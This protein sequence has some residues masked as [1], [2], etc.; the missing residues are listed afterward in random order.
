MLVLCNSL[1]F[2]LKRKKNNVKEGTDRARGLRLRA[3]ALR[4]Q[5]RL[6]SCDRFLP[7]RHNPLVL[8]YLVPSTGKLFHHKM[9]LRNLRPDSEVPDVMA[10]L[11]KRHAAYLVS[12]RVSETQIK[13][14]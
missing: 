1:S 5:V 12:S 6:S 2:Y 11:G 13:G 3:Q 7:Q 4:P 9:K 10:E 14:S 8:E